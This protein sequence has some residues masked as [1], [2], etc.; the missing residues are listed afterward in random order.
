ME[1]I[2]RDFIEDTPAA[3]S[4]TTEADSH[5][6][7]TSSIPAP[8]P[9]LPPP[10]EDRTAPTPADEDEDEDSR[11]TKVSIPTIEKHSLFF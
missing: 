4:P 1:K 7:V 6:R 3:Q 11:P 8:G 9:K 2:A 5:L 10:A